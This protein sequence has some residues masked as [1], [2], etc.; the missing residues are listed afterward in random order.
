[1]RQHPEV[2]EQLGG[3][4]PVAQSPETRQALPE[5]RCRPNHIA[6]RPL[7]PPKLVECESKQVP[8]SLLLRQYPAQFIVAAGSLMI[9]L[10]SCHCTQPEMAPGDAIFLTQLL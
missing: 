10:A 8:I 3:P 4:L 7:N 5:E 6:L 2:A 1:M 9:L